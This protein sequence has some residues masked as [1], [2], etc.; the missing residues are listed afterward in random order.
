MSK[1]LGTVLKH[2]RAEAHMTQQ[3]AA[4]KLGLK[5]KSTLASWESGKSEPSIINFLQL[6][7]Y[8]NIP[9]AVLLANKIH[10]DQTAIWDFNEFA[11]NNINIS[12]SFTYCPYCG[13]ELPKDNNE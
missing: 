10:L 7:M 1:E 5:N 13:K 4:D 11:N 3:A 2:L 6:C 9:E 12:T 8:Y